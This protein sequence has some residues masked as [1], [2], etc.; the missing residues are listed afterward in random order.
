[1]AKKEKKNGL[2]PD[3]RCIM[4]AREMMGRWSDE[5]LLA[6]DPKDLVEAYGV[7]LRA[8]QNLLKEG[9]RERGLL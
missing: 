8:A 6:K 9:K 5:Y 2:A 7:T 1:M 3:F 4:V